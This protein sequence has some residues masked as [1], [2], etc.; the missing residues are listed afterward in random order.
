M[1]GVVDEHIVDSIKQTVLFCNEAKVS[2]SSNI[3]FEKEPSYTRRVL[4]LP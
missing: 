4:K 1:N 3:V 2:L